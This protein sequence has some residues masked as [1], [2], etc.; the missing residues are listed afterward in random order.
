[1]II[2]RVE[3]IDGGG[4]FYYPDGSPRMEGFPKFGNFN[5]CHGLDNYE[6][7][8]GIMKKYQLDEKIYRIVQYYP[9]EVE[10]IKYNLING[11]VVFKKLVK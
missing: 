2:Y 9:Y 6:K 5:I 1:M 8:Q 10:I 11:E 4:P 3:H 7:V